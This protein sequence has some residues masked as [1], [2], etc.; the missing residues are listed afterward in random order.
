MPETCIYKIDYQYHSS[1]SLGFDE[2][3]MIDYVEAPKNIW[4]DQLETLCHRHIPGFFSLNSFHAIGVR[5]L[6]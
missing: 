1:F 2:S 3:H 5:K 4:R 6:V